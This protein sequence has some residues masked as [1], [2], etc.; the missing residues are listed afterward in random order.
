MDRPSGDQLIDAIATSDSTRRSS[1]P[2]PVADFRYRPHFPARTEA[3]TIWLPSGDQIGEEFSSEA[4]NVNREVVP[5]ANFRHPDV[6]PLTVMTMRHHPRPVGRE[7][8]S[9]VVR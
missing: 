7:V 1:A 8:Q 5:R 3:K 4:S 9:S 2:A 6:A